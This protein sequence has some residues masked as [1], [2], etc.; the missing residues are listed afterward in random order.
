MHK[1]RFFFS[2]IKTSLIAGKVKKQRYIVESAVL[3]KYL[4][5]TAFL[6]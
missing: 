6:K 1:N 3:E 4:H 5:K 2:R